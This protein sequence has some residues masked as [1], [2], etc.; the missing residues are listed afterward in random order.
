MD[1]ERQKEMQTIEYRDLK[2]A[3][4]EAIKQKDLPQKTSQRR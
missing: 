3:P 1:D 2:K 4:K